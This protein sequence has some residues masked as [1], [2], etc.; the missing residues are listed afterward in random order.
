MRAKAETGIVTNL[1]NSVE[2]ENLLE[3]N[4]CLDKYLLDLERP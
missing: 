3:I 4:D 2:H 1:V